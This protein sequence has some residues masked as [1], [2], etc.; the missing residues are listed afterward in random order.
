MATLF[1]AE[2]YL[3]HFAAKSAWVVHDV[4]VRLSGR[5]MVTDGDGLAGLA[6]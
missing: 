1:G 5:T 3:R 4:S 2:A 6:T